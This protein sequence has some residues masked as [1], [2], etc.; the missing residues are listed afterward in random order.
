MVDTVTILHQRLIREYHCSINHLGGFI[1]IR[2]DYY[3]VM[4]IKTILIF[5][6]YHSDS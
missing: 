1:V 4:V 5:N 6:H 2:G 3:Q